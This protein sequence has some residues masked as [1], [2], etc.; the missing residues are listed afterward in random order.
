M[1][2]GVHCPTP[3][4][5]LAPLLLLL[6]GAWGAPASAQQGRLVVFAAASLKDAL[7]EVNAAY[8]RETNQEIATS[9]AASPTLAK[10]IEAA[11]PADIFISAD[12][13]WMN[14][15][16]ER[17]LIKPGSRVDLLGNTLVLI[18]P[19]NSTASITIGLNFPLASLL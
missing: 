17:K 2:R 13:D 5:L 14:Y 7:D 19:A 6:A 12:L 18:A 1:E 8:R 4:A 11:A 10:Q 16:D 15:L 3:L 9:Y